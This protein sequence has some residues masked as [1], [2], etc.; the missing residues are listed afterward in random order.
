MQETKKP[1]R[2][3]GLKTPTQFEYHTRRFAE[4]GLTGDF[5]ASND[6][7]ILACNPT[8]VRML[9]F[10]NREAAVGSNFFDLLPDARRRESILHLLE[11]RGRIENLE[12]EL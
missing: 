1:K 8:Y 10:P 5:I 6:G 9:G 12:T 2:S 7:H 3:Q 11:K 4:S